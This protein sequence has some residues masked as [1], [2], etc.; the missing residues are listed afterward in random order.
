VALD[1]DLQE[2]WWQDFAAQDEGV[3]GA[4]DDGAGMRVGAVGVPF[5]AVGSGGDQLSGVDLVGEAIRSTSASLSDSAMGSQVRLPSAVLRYGQH[6]SAG[7]KAR[8]VRTSSMTGMVWPQL[9]P[10]SQPTVP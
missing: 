7:S 8:P 6:S 5:H 9:A 10:T 2:V 3:D 1:V 4:A